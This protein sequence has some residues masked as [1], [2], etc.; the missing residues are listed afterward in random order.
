MTSHAPRIIAEIG[1]NHF[2]DINIAK[3]LIRESANAGADMVKFQYR[4]LNRIYAPTRNYSEIGDEIVK[5]EI[6]ANYLNPDAICTLSDFARSLGLSPGISFFC[7]DDIKDIVYEFDFFKIPSVELTN[8]ELILS[9]LST[10]KHTYIST[11]CSK[12]SE[13]IAI[14]ER[15]KK[16]NNWT[17]MHCISNY[18][19]NP[20]N[21][22]LG[23]LKRLH[24]LSGRSVG[25]SSHE[26]DWEYCIIAATLGATVIERHITLR[27]DAKGLD[28]SSSSSPAEFSQMRRI[29]NNL[30]AAMQGENTSRKLNQGER[31]N[32]QN[33][34]RSL[35]AKGPFKEGHLLTIEDLEERSPCVGIRKNDFQQLTLTTLKRP[36]LQGEPLTHAH[37]CDSLSSSYYAWNSNQTSLATAHSLSLPVRLHDFS[38]IFK[39]FSLSNYEFHLSHEEILGSKINIKQLPKHCKYSIHLPDY[40]SST[41]LIDPFS[42]DA[43]IAKQS[44]II[45][46]RTMVF[47][48]ELQQHTGA[49]VPVIGSFSQRLGSRSR[50]YEQ[51]KQLTYELSR[52]SCL[53]LPQWLP[54]IAWYFGGSVDL[55]IFNSREDIAYIEALEIDICLDVCHFLMC[56]AA[57]SIESQDFKKLLRRSRHLHIADAIG[58]DGEGIQLLAGDA[59][60]SEFIT[61]AILDPTQA[62]VLEVWQGHLYD[63]QG[64]SEALSIA[65]SILRDK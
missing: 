38:A 10:D 24:I 49:T 5:K 56:F 48:K 41:D 12:E 58:T 62:K 54:P 53:L 59:A 6:E 60:N 37:L 16:Y 28:H 14:I 27:R 45:I 64:F 29:L 19:V 11:G 47:A 7:K 40:I 32:L 13:I 33:L 17:L 46:D 34:G 23:Y 21:S 55:T 9:L 43:A 65:T 22:M 26:E 61:E 50:F 25:Y 51:C 39:K 63:Y 3:K 42:S 36:L 1:I 4:N 35:Y 30:Q 15:L 2:G 8:I 20:R 57:H 52:Q 18:P 31:L 44:S